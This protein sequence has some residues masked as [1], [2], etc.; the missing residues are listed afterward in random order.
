MT[1]IE[2]QLPSSRLTLAGDAEAIRYLEQAIT[3]GK[4]WYIALL[5][6]IGLWASVEET[7]GGGVWHGCVGWGGRVGG[8]EPLAGERSR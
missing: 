1:A 8:G 6:A 3:G 7:H 5:E 2:N 4:H